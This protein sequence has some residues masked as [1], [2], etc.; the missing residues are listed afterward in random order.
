MPLVQKLTKQGLGKPWRCICVLWMLSL[1]IVKISGD[2]VL[3]RIVNTKYGQIQ[4]LVRHH[5]TPALRPVEVFVG[6]PYASPPIGEGRFT[7]TSS[8]L[9]WDNVKRCTKLP[10]VCPQ[11]ILDDK[12]KTLPPDLA[13]K[14]SSMKP[15]LEKQSEDCLYLNIYAP[16]DGKY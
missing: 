9:P 2:Q 13:S 3:S 6:V 14:L 15:L 4:G 7:P 1:S 11:P 12:D 5:G 10:P 16:H 8:Q